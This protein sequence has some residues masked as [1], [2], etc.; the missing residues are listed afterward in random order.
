MNQ[1][2]L[3]LRKAYGIFGNQTFVN[4]ELGHAYAEKYNYDSAM[5]YY[6]IAIPLAIQNHTEV[7][8]ID[9]YSGIAN[10]YKAKGNL[11]SVVWYAKKAPAEKSEKT[12]PIGQLRTATMLAEF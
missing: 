7:D 10:L 9:I 4:V 2:I 5:H 6:R 11:D 3:F 1:P 8:L 12:Y